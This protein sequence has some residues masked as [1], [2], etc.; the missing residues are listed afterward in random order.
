MKTKVRETEKERDHFKAEFEK[1]KIERRVQEI[2]VERK[3][4]HAK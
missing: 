1:L 2:E 3:K 4:D